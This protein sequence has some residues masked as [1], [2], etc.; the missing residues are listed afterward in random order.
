MI[1]AVQII[2]AIIIVVLVFIV[3]KK[4]QGMKI[5]RAFRIIIND[6][7]QQGALNPSSAVTLPYASPV[8]FRIGLRD[9]RPRAIN[10][11][12]QSGIVGMTENGQFYLKR[13]VSEEALKGGRS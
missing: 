7:K 1:E 13:D 11:L 9:Y 3:A 5:N 12:V 10:Y 2:L 6:L 8:L 4:I